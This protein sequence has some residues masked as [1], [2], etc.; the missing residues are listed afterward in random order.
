MLL[1][2]CSPLPIVR[3]LSTLQPD[4]MHARVPP[5]DLLQ[6]V[7]I[8]S[9]AHEFQLRN[10]CNSFELLIGRIAYTQ[11]FA[12]PQNDTEAIRMGRK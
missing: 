2:R 3:V 1:K 9:S 10:F 6:C 12:D 7:L 11:H 5:T 8:D 4:S